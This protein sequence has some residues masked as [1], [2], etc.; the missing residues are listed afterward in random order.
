MDFHYNYQDYSLL[1]HDE[2]STRS[3]VRLMIFHHNSNIRRYKYEYPPTWVHV[4]YTY[5]FIT[6]ATV[7]T[8]SNLDKKNKEEQLHP[9]YKPHMNH[10]GSHD[11]N[12]PFL[13]IYN[14]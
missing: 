13:S 10:T 4:R 9:F 7:E 5:I 11:L 14:L 8:V 3:Q 6:S 2:N 1:V 12:P